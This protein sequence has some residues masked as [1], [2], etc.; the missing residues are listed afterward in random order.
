MSTTRRRGGVYSKPTRKHPRS[1]RST[2]RRYQRGVVSKRNEYAIRASMPPSMRHSL[3]LSRLPSKREKEYDLMQERSR[4]QR[5]EKKAREEAMERAIAAHK[6][7]EARRAKELERAS[8]LAEKQLKSMQQKID[9]DTRAASRN[10]ARRE[11][12]ERI[13]S[14]FKKQRGSLA[15]SGMANA[16]NQAVEAR[17]YD[18]VLAMLSGMS[19]AANARPVAPVAPLGWTPIRNPN[20]ESNEEY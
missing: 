3:E 1:A 15:M 10:A 2:R 5:E 6:R 18:Q 4:Q 8:A 7:E 16:L 14:E 9:R 17:E 20:A 12:M 11:M 19:F 13:Q